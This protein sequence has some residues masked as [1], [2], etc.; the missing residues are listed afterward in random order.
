M[1]ADVSKTSDE[2]ARFWTA[3][4]AVAQ[5]IGEGG[6]GYFPYQLRGEILD[7]VRTLSHPLD[8]YRELLTT[9][10]DPV[11]REVL[12][13]LI[14]HTDDPRADA[15]LIDALDAAGL[16]PRA[17]YLLGAIGTKGWPSRDRDVPVILSAIERYLG[18]HTA[19]VDVY[20]RALTFETADFARAAYIRVAG[21]ERFPEVH[22]LAGFPDDPSGRF[23]GMSLPTFTPE[24]RARLDAA[25][26]RV[27]A[28]RTP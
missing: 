15:M 19:Y 1:Q 21:V 4:R 12:L 5:P 27:R 9:E 11:W 2:A 8:V 7:Q 10:R 26:G 6:R 14:A 24:D 22:G 28:A 25:I 20:W 17:L 3:V 16:R 18:D 23:I 13:F